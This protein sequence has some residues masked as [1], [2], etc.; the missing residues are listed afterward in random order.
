[1]MWTPHNSENGEISTELEKKDF[2]FTRKGRGEAIENANLLLLIF[3]FYLNI[4]AKNIT[5]ILALGR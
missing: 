1:M 2:K 3:F 4:L 5:Y